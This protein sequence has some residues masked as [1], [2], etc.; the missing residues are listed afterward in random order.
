MDRVEPTASVRL[1]SVQNRF[2]SVGT[3]P[4]QTEVVH[5]CQCDFSGVEMFLA[6]LRLI[7]HL[8]VF[9]STLPSTKIQVVSL[10]YHF[11][12][13]LQA[14]QFLHIDEYDLFL[15]NS[16]NTIFD[17][18]SHITK[19]VTFLQSFPLNIILAIAVS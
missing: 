1:D 18:I 16:G 11:L 15:S 6:F 9:T 10:S 7:P 13:A 12:Q 4:V 8:E 5:P 17:F 3:G 14:L 2:D 19:V